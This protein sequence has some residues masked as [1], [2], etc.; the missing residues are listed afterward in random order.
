MACC[1]AEITWV[2]SESK[3]SP[4]MQE[5]YQKLGFSE[6][7]CNQEEWY[8]LLHKMQGAPALPAIQSGELKHLE[9]SLGGDWNWAYFI[10][11]ENRLL[12]TWAYEIF[13]DVVTFEDLA[14]DGVEKYV[15]R[16]EEL[17]GD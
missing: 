15:A 3:P 13:L 9:E 17:Q 1:V 11:F 4:E 2:D 16:M 12:E 8:F 5:H 6:L 14:K 10:D 7:E